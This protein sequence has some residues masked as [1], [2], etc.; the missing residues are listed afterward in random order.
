M[1][2]PAG[3]SL[4]RCTTV[5]R[6]EHAPCE[7][8]LVTVW[9]TSGIELCSPCGVGFFGG[10]AAAAASGSCGRCGPSGWSVGA[11]VPSSRTWPSPWVSGWW[12]AERRLGLVSWSKGQD[13][14]SWLGWQVL[15]LG[16]LNHLGGIA[17][18]WRVL[19]ASWLVGY[20]Q[21]SVLVE[22]GVDQDAL[23]EDVVELL[24]EV[25]GCRTLRLILLRLVSVSILPLVILGLRGC[26][27]GA[28]FRFAQ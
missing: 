21:L 3:K 2:L 20:D 23:E 8:R 9:E 7:A 27:V 28:P 26:F 18:L 10:V 24:L 15:A 17:R 22:S 6:H 12:A 25:V 1:W 19:G 13:G 11:P 14:W 4:L 5:P 16:H